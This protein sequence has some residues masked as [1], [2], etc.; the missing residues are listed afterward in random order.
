MAYAYMFKYIVIGDT[1]VGKSCLLLQ[2]TDKRFR[3][4]HDVTIGVEFGSKTIDIDGKPTKLQIWDTAGQES[5]RSI[6]RSYYR[7]AAGA[8]IVYDISRRETFDH[9]V[10][11]LDEVRQQSDRKTIITLIGNKS[12]LT[13]RV[14][15]DEGSRFAKENGL[16]FTETSARS[17]DMVDEAFCMTARE[18]Y[19]NIQKGVYDLSTDRNGIKIGMPLQLLSTY[20]SKDGSQLKSKEGT[21]C[22]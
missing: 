17:D 11:W 22:A 18:I 15:Y 14:S 6:T 4:E 12:D 9:V 10:R 5:F 21:C 7:G 20:P 3:S 2:F 1:S 8:L 13:R 19:R 16:L